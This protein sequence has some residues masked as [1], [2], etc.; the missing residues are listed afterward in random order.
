VSN[1]TG[2][3]IYLT[4]QH[5]ILWMSDKLWLRLHFSENRIKKQDIVTSEFLTTKM[6]ELCIF[7]G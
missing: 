5:G 3:E 6:R 4:S 2:C 1:V 7:G